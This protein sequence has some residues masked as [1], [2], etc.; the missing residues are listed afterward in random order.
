[1]AIIVTW[2]SRVT[3]DT[4]SNS[5]YVCRA[6]LFSTQ[7]QTASMPGSLAIAN[8]YVE[9]YKIAFAI[10]NHIVL[11][12]VSFWRNLF[13]AS[14]IEMIIQNCSC[15]PIFAGIGEH[16]PFQLFQSNFFQVKS[17]LPMS[18]DSKKLCSQQYCFKCMIIICWRWSSCSVSHQCCVSTV[19][20]SAA[21]GWSMINDQFIT[22]AI[23]NVWMVQLI[24]FLGGVNSCTDDL[25]RSVSLIHQS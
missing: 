9:C 11:I 4:I 13:L 8:W 5:F 18:P 2:Q 1:M 6:M 15:Q 25:S 21:V 22:L 7:C 20:H 12:K 10:L 3:L 23:D 24:F 16:Q 17:T 14:M 19:D